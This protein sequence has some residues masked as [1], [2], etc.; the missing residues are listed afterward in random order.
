MDELNPRHGVAFDHA[1]ILKRKNAN[2]TYYEI[3]VSG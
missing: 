2:A 3:Q 1:G